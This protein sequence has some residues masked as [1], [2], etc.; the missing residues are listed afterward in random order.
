M[1]QELTDEEVEGVIAMMAEADRLEALS[2]RE[3]LTEV[4]DRL[5]LLGPDCLLADE[6]VKRLR[7][8]AAWEIRRERARP[9]RRR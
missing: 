1:S 3:L 4:N 7:K 5:P 8:L 9:R 6:I 2:T